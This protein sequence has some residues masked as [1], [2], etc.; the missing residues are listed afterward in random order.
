MY[1]VLP[2]IVEDVFF[3]AFL[4]AELCLFDTVVQVAKCDGWSSFLEILVNAANNVLLFRH[5]QKQ[6]RYQQR[7]KRV[8]KSGFEW[9]EKYNLQSDRERDRETDES[10]CNQ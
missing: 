3:R 5:L 4:A 2:Y 10:T 6:Q 1:Y 9:R 7:R 8:R